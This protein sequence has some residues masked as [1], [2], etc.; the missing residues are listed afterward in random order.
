VKIDVNEQAVMAAQVK[1]LAKF[2]LTM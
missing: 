2:D 1:L